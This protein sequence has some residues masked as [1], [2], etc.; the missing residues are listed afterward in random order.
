MIT[1]SVK[2]IQ[3]V[4][5]ALRKEMEKLA[6]GNNMVLVGIQESAG[7]E[8]SGMT[9]A[10][11]GAVHEYGAK[12]EHPGGTSYG[13]KDQKAAEQGQVRFLKKGEGFMELG[14]TGPHEIDIPARPWLE[15]GVEDG[16]HEYLN[17]VEDG[18]AKDVPKDRILNQL[19]V[20]AV[21]NVQQKIVEVHEPPNAKSTIQKKGSS[22]PLIDKGVIRQSVSYLLTK[23]IPKEGLE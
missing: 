22:N 10:Q 23:D 17:I 5:D 14:V 21:A 11:I 20:L 9:V 4:K 16:T 13:F 12:I 18:L 2:G 15:P 19:G 1:S 6:E 3:E 8:E 7:E